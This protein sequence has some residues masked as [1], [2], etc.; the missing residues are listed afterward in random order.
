MIAW[1][2]ASF[3]QLTPG[4]VHDVFQARSQV[5]VVE[6]G[7][8]FQDL[9]GADPQCWHLLGL[10]GGRLV[11]Y[12]RLV[13]AGVKFAEPSIGRVITTGEARGTGRGKELVRE[14]LARAAGLWPGH[15]IRIGAQAHLE[16]FYR[17][18]GFVTASEPYLEDG[19]PHI[20]MV[21]SP[22]QAAR[23]GAHAQ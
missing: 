14:A 6:Q 2:F 10:E 3:A 12:C 21:R 19:I 20:E 1:R 22:P 8:A 23:R 17:A 16:R 9:D 4:E 11:A 15:A 7:C 5:F 18:F 13:P